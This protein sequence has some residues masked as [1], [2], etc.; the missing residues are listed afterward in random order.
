V[1]QVEEFGARARL[2]EVFVR[3]NV[4][5]HIECSLDGDLQRV[6]D[7]PRLAH[8]LIEHRRARQAA[9]VGHI[10]LDRRELL[11]DE[12][13]IGQRTGRGVR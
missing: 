3:D 2:A 9:Q 13:G 8:V 11:G 10:C 5:R 4:R 7:E 6:L 1:E 12:I